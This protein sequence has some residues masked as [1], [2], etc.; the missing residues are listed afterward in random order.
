MT[1]YWACMSADLPAGFLSSTF[2]S[3]LLLTKSG[4]WAGCSHGHPPPPHSQAVGW[5]P[6]AGAMPRP[7]LPPVNSSKICDAGFE[8]VEPPLLKSPTLCQVRMSEGD[9]RLN[10]TASL[11]EPSKESPELNLT[12][13][14]SGDH[15]LPT[16]KPHSIRAESNVLDRGENMF[17]GW[18][19][20]QKNQ[21]RADSPDVTE[22]SGISSQSSPELDETDSSM[23]RTHQYRKVMKPM[24]ERKR[25]AR[26]NSCLEELKD[27]MVEA[28]QTEGESITKLEKADV[29]ELTVRH[30]RKLKAHG[31]LSL[32][33]TISY[34]ERYRA[35]YSLCASEV[36]KFLRSSGGEVEMAVVARLLHRLSVSLRSMELHSG[37]GEGGQVSSRMAHLL[38]TPL[39][40]SQPIISAAGAG[41]SDLAV[42]EDSEEKA[43]RPW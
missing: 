11:A 28:L 7:R 21:V 15:A 33:P 2:P 12:G 18:G 24:L 19:G 17:V 26:I 23:S 27:L 35:G 22:D 36:S 4:Q 6:P 39:Q 8:S 13:P 10:F 20:E 31:A 37:Q 16:N 41:R 29:L 38:G 34:M 42:M 43:W 1:T 30:L 9:S 32:T 14:S 3:H 25:R 5:R 40:A